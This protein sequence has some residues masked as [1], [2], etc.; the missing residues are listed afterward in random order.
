MCGCVYYKGYE[1]G[2][3]YFYIFFKKKINNNLYYKYEF[4][5]YIFGI[6]CIWCMVIIYVYVYFFWNSIFELISVLFNYSM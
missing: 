5:Y 1:G 6:L 4:V 2:K 3:I